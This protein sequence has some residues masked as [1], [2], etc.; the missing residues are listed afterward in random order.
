M[1]DV[2]L[3]PMLTLKHGLLSEKEK[4]MVLANFQRDG[5]PTSL[6]IQ[7][8]DIFKGPAPVTRAQGA[9]PEKSG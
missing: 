2:Y 7:I 4:D 1:S 3:Q 6:R 5:G 9:L 8:N